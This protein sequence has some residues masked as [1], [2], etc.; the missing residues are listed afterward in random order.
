MSGSGIK[1]V[2]STG[3]RWIDHKMRAMARLIEKFGLYTHH[4]HNIIADTSKSC[5]RATL[6]GKFDR[7]IN[8]NV[9][10]STCRFFCGCSK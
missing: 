1:P 9:I 2:K 7:L 4:L 8:A 10:N 5:D 6:H 3:T